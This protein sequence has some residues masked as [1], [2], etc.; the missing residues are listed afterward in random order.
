M[1][2][3]H[4]VFG[5]IRILELPT[6]ITQ[7]FAQIDFGDT[8]LLKYSICS[9]PLRGNNFYFLNMRKLNPKRVSELAKRNNSRKQIL[10]KSIHFIAHKSFFL[11][12]EKPELIH[13]WAF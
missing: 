9:K 13:A 1:N 4:E 5:W 12:K 6:W 2:L 7:L 11:Y 10:N 8:M 3:R